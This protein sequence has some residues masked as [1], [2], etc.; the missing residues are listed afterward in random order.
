MFDTKL[1]KIPDPFFRCVANR[2]CRSVGDETS[3][4][5]ICINCNISAHLFCNEYLQPQ[6]PVEEL[7]VIA[8]KDLSKE[9]KLRWKKIPA[10]E[11]N[12]VVFCILCQAKIKAVKVFASAAK[13]VEKE[14]KR[15]V[16]E[17]SK[18]KSIDKPSST[19][20]PCIPKASAHIIR[21]LCCVAA[22]QA[23][24]I[25]FTKVDKT[26]KVQRWAL[27]EEYFHGN[28]KKGIV[29]VC[30]Q[31]VNGEGPFC[32]LYNLVEGEHTVELVL[33]PSCCGK[34]TALSY[35]FG[36][37]FSVADIATFGSNNKLM[38]G[39]AIWDMVL[40]VLWLMKK[41]LSLV[42]KLSPRIVSLIRIV[43]WSDMHRERTKEVSSNISTKVCI[44]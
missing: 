27:I 34:D 29:G 18:R 16:K 14:S 11:K 15:K 40:N 36:T 6:N 22:F 32:A 28:E 44:L 20:K 41:A 8:L 37:N 4:M 38:Q 21:E 19:K 7:H 25:L 33:E 10:S 42:P 35:V 12:N 43:L 24:L 1:D 31:L 9:G 17:D 23:Q 2:L 26:K 30:T 13:L 3:Q 39:R 5:L